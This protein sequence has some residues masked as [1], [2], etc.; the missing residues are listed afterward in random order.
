MRDLEYYVVKEMEK[1]VYLMWCQVVYIY[2][3]C[4]DFWL[5]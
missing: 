5:L 2:L 1:R 4:L 3:G